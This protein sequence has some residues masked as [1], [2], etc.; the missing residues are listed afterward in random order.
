MLSR[1]ATHTNL[2]VFGFTWSGLT[3]STHTIYYTVWFYLIRTHGEHTCHLLHCLVLPDQD[4]RWAHLPFI[5]PFG[6]TWSGLTVSTPTIY[7]TVWFSLIRTHDEHTYH[8]LHRL[9]LSDQ[10]SRWAHLP[11]IT[12]FGFTWSGLTVSTLTIYYTVWF[13]LIR[14][15]GEH[16]YHLLHHLVLP[17][18]DSRWAHLPFITPFGFTWSGLTVSTLTIYYINDAVKCKC[19]K[20][21]YINSHSYIKH[22]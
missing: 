5:T 1:D 18:Q 13:Y 19:A 8:L 21:N 20:L 17:D 7:Y 2:I 22:L 16:T 4:S 11:F 15:H 3:V 14:T 9:V 6:F 10:D 12:P